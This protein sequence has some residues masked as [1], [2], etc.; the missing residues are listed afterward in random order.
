VISP[1][2]SGTL[3]SGV[4]RAKPAVLVPVL[5]TFLFFI[6]A[7]VNP[8][9]IDEQLETLL[10]DYRFKV[11]NLIAPPRLPE[12]ILI[13][14]I[15]EKSLAEFGRWPWPR[16]L[17]GRLIEDIF[18]AHPA[19]VALDIFYAEPESPDADRAFAEL[20]SRH[21]DRL[22][23][24]LGFEAEQGKF[25]RGDVE[26]EL[27][28]QAIPK[29]ENTKSLFPTEACRVLLPP[30]TIAGAANFGHVYAQPDRDGKLR[31]ES[32]FIKYGDEYFPSLALQT[33]RIS[34][35]V[36][37]DNVRI[38]GGSGVRLGDRFIPTDRAGRLDI[39]YLGPEKSLQYVS[40]ADVL[41]GRTAKDIFRDRIIAV[42]TSAIATYDQ[43]STPFSANYPG[44]EKNATVVANILSGSFIRPS[45]LLSTLLSVLGFGLLLAVV[46]RRMKA[47]AA[48]LTFLSAAALIVVCNQLLFTYSGMLL[49]LFYPLATVITEG[50]FII[51]HRYFIEEKRAKDIRKIFSSY[52]S[53]KIVEEIIS[54]PEKAVLCGE[55]KTVTVLFSDLI[56]F[57]S[58]SERNEPEKVVAL[59]N[60]Y[61]HE[62]ARIIFKWDGTL[63]KFMGDEIM[64]FWGAPAEQPDHA[65]R[66]VRCALDMAARLA[67]LQKRW[68]LKGEER[69][70]CGIGINTGEVIIGNIGAEG[71][72]MDY[73]AIG[74][75]VNIASR[76][77]KLT[78]QYQAKVILTEFTVS[79][80]RG[81]ITAG[82]FGHMDLKFVDTVTV[83]GKG[84]GLQIY[85][86]QDSEAKERT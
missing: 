37:R 3:P 46:S 83:K 30:E 51:S 60:E 54:H 71:R 82:R 21:R 1:K 52:V 84:K 25:F 77:E 36:S 13:V 20:L 75:H 39:N 38:I 80:I 28:D 5:L 27:L 2:R 56:G 31:K 67:E 45:L 6:L 15:D 35:G 18:S 59:L 68:T 86:L 73:T 70:D 55:K 9:F 23:V 34:L 16:H 76:V 53:P 11:R 4:L 65:E 57:T 72:K 47:L 58:I 69:L 66:A 14:A 78:R 10:L 74:D 79:H 40:A 17:Q 7:I 61:F 24:A 32:L 29:I 48:I 19:V 33:A 49:N 81:L 42:G 41:S 26:E 64:A 63:D 44:V 50:I 62:M 43:K 8:P 85:V 12:N 22:V